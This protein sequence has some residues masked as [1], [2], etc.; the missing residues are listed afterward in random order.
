MTCRMFIYTALSAMMV[1]CTVKEDRS[2][3]PCLLALDFADVDTTLVQMAE[4]S[5]TRRGTEVWSDTVDVSRRVG[6]YNTYVPRDVLHVRVW[7]GTGGFAS[8]DGL[9]IPLGQDCPEIYMHNSYVETDGEYCHEEIDMHKGYCVMTVVVKGED[10]F[11]LRM[12]VKGF[13]SG[14]SY[15]GLPHAGD[16]EYVLK[17]GDLNSGYQVV[18]PRQKDS[19]LLL[20][21]DDE[22]ESKAFAIG[23]Y[24][25]DSGYDWS[26]PDLE[27]VTVTVDYAL[28]EIRLSIKGWES[29]YVYDMIM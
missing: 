1:A 25:I 26:S 18:L 6:R 2:S 27:D 23:R 21:I 8:R 4:V 15:E 13:V 14:Y 7:S 29:V 12:T 10:I 11:P 20:M 28:T 5:L 19:S 16:F 22:G 24:I 9:S 17:D 3:C